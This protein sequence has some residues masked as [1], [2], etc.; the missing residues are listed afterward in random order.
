M[1]ELSIQED[2]HGIT[3]VAKI[4]PGSGRTAIAGVLDHM[5][6][7]KVAAPREKNK[8]NQCLIAFL[9]KK[10]NV[11]KNSISI[12]MGQTSP[13]KHMRIVEISAGIF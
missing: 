6:K 13:V 1:S 5:V 10:L 11:K 3:F 7:V 8:A 2:D 4:V 9:A 12:T